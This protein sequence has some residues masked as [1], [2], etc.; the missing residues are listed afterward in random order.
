MVTS[1][2]ALEGT[3]VASGNGAAL[4]V[5]LCALRIAMSRVVRSEELGSAAD[6]YRVPREV[7]P[8]TRP[9]A[10]AVDAMRVMRAGNAMVSSTCSGGIVQGDLLL[11][12]FLFLL[13]RC[14]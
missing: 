10:G 7:E 2:A 1:V 14:S 12:L 5:E 4:G 6:P 3:S 8:P 9:P 13:R 11:A